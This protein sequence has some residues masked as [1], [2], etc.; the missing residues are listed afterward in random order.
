MNEL[1]NGNAG[2]PKTFLS[3]KLMVAIKFLTVSQTLSSL[4][5][6]SQSAIDKQEIDS[7]WIVLR[8]FNSNSVFYERCALMKC[9]YTA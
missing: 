8:I 5:L 2:P 6:I 4:V 9:L 1:R 7:Y 3:S